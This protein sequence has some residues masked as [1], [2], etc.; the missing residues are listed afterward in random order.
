MLFHGVGFSLNYIFGSSKCCIPERLSARASR[1]ICWLRGMR[2]YHLV[3]FDAVQYP[4][5]S[6][7]HLALVGMSASW[8][9]VRL[10]VRALSNTYVHFADKK[11]NGNAYR[12]CPAHVGNSQ[13]YASDQQGNKVLLIGFQ[14]AQQWAQFQAGKNQ[15]HTQH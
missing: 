11:I 13:G 12:K 5:C 14:V 4:D 8:M 3:Q 2:L 6:S 10:Y 7:D 9:G 15:E 1:I